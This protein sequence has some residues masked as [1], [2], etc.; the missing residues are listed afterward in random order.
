MMLCGVFL[1]AIMGYISIWMLDVIYNPGP[2][3][4]QFTGTQE[5]KFAIFALFAGILV[6]GL[7]SFIT[8]G[9]QALFGRRNRTLSW[10]VIGLGVVIFAGGGAVVWFFK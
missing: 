9:W 1:I 4:G 10:I 8:G 3:K 5:E 7:G 6:F 2:S